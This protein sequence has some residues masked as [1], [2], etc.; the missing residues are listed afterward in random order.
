MVENTRVITDTT[1]S[2][3]KEPTP[4]QT[5]A[6][7]AASGLMVCSMELVA[8]SALKALT[9]RGAYGRSASSNSG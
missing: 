6:G 3:A 7:I 8:S 2:T 5:A 9:K 4:T 1:R